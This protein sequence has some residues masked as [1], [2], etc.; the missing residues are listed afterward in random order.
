MDT[1]ETFYGLDESWFLSRNSAFTSAEIARQGV[2][3]RNLGSYLLAKKADILQFAGRMGGFRGRR[4]ILTGAGSSAFAG[5]AA[6]L[7]AGKSRGLP[8]ES[9]H[10]TDIVSSP[11]SVLFPDVPTLLVSF[12]RS[13]SSPESAGAVQYA[14]KIVK[15]LWELA[16][17]CDSGSKLAG[18]TSESPKGLCLVMPEG[19]NDKGFAMTSSFTCMTLAC[20][21]VL[22][23]GEIETIAADIH[24]L[25]GVF[26]SRGKALVSAAR[27][28]AAV[29]YDRLIVLG[30]GCL[31]GLARE[32][33]LKSMELTGGIVNTGWDSPMGFRHGPKAVIKDKTLTVHFISSDPFTAR[34]DLDLLAEISRQKKGN[35]IIALSGETLS[36]PVDGN[37]VI[38][39]EQYGASGE[40][41]RGI[42]YLVFCQ[43]LALF[44]SLA[45]GF[46]ADNPV[47]SGEITRVVSGVTLYGLGD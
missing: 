37:I 1:W 16:L 42:S 12:G 22:G 44:K 29:D 45:L 40:L 9:V 7:A 36:V 5:E 8:V 25:G 24:R 30:S 18:I 3:W 35:R 26:D 4:I 43:L 47:P 19:A 28:W 31:R 15:D 6:A 17:V 13:G 14:R 39:G 11:Y 23:I 21:A 33:A 10:T 32:A 41:C 34:Y 2:L 20:C 46:S 38:G 27:K